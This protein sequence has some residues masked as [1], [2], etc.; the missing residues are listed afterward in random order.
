MSIIG[1]RFERIL[2]AAHLGVGVDYVP[3]QAMGS[4]PAV[5]VPGGAHGHVPYAAL[6]VTFRDLVNRLVIAGYTP[7]HNHW[8]D[9]QKGAQDIAYKTQDLVTVPVKAIRAGGI[10]GQELVPVR[11]TNF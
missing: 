11:L 4:G 9:F 1:I 3:V 6:P 2:I 7:E 8:A 5:Y 10:K